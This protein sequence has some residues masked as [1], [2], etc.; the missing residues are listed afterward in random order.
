[1]RKIYWRP[2]SVSR[3]VL[4]VLSIISL[5]GLAA[6]EWLKTPEQQPYYEEM[7]AAARLAYQAMEVIQE[8]QLERGVVDPQADPTRSGLIG[9]V[10]SP[11]TSDPGVLAAKQTSVNPNFAAVVVQMLREAGVQPGDTV[12]VGFSGSFPA[13]NISVLAAVEMLR[14]KPVIITSAAASQWGANDPDFLW[15]DMERLLNRQGLFHHR[16]VAASL[17]GQEDRAAGMSEEGIR[18]LESGIER[19]RHLH[20]LTAQSVEE[21]V[22]Q[23]MSIY[24]DHA[25]DA[26]IAAYLN[27]GGGTVSVGG[28]TGKR[29]FRAGVNFRVPSG[30]I[31]DSVMA[32]FVARG[33]PAIHL[34][35]IEQLADQ[36]GLPLRPR[37][38]P[39]PGEGGVFQMQAY[40]RWLAAGVLVFILLLLYAF[41][42]TAL[43]YRILQASPSREDLLY[44]EPM[45]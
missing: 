19:H 1:M 22:E 9:Q 11:V 42:R 13:I 43:G 24:L 2:R 8:H 23:R 44:H 36:Y 20:R 45:V 21:S 16:S 18:L 39:K 32:R 28:A 37:T 6:V 4:I 5:A 12:A 10:M 25:G 26:P 14:L 33:V 34:I 35:R 15:L 27:V 29:S 41:M 7:R 38:M 30:R 3:P 40:N 31:S 17:G